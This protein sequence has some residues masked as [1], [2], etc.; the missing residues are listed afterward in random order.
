MKYEVWLDNEMTGPEKI[1]IFN[2]R[3]E[4]DDFVSCRQ[5]WDSYV[6]EVKTNNRGSF[7]ATA[8]FIIFSAMTLSLAFLLLSREVR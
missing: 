8:F 7:Y 2:D 6:L 3:K 5:P 4:A 1:K